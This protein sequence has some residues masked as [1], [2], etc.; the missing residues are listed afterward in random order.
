MIVM[1][2]GGGLCEEGGAG[3]C[4][5]GDI[6]GDGGDASEGRA[7]GNEELPFAPPSPSS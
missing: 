5:G 4:S 2:K 7:A 6:G 1:P 3:G